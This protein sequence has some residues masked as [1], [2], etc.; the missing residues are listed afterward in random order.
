M[1]FSLYSTESW[2]TEQRFFVH[3]RFSFFFHFLFDRTL[4]DIIYNDTLVLTGEVILPLLTDI[5]DGMSYLHEQGFVHGQLV[6]GVSPWGKKI[7]T[8]ILFSLVGRF[9]LI[10]DT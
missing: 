8:G 7:K 9:A 3:L 1:S 10:S 4:R 5:A 6:S 2:V